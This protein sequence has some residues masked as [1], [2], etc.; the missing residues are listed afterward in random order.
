M[1]NI[2]LMIVG[3]GLFLNCSSQNYLELA[4]TQ[5]LT[6]AG[7]FTFHAQKA[8]AVGADINAV[9][10]AIPNYT[11]TRLTTLDSGYTLVIEKEKLT[12]TLPYFG[13]LYNSN[14]YDTNKQSLRF[15]SEDFTVQK[16]TS[17]KG[18]AVFMIRPNDVSH[19]SMINIEVYSNGKAFVSVDATDRQPISYDGYI[20]ANETVR[21]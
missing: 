10:N 16:S 11:P 13:R 5:Q 19:I 3:L 14:G 20:A 1:K 2:F 12:C 15:T 17:K 9:T 18:N 8:N 7:D 4:A 21:K 6:S